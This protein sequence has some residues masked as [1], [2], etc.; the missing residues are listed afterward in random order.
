MPLNIR[1]RYQK[2]LQCLCEKTQLS[3]RAIAEAT[4]IAKS[5]VHRHLK[6]IERRQQYAESYLWET[7]EGEDWRSFAGVWGDLLLRHQRGNWGGE[8]VGIFPSVAPGSTDRL[9]LQVLYGN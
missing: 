1:E 3:L 2:V 6:T 5:S 7:L 8:S 4:G 9:L